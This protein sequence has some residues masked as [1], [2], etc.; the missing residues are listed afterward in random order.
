MML[1]DSSVMIN[2]LKIVYLTL[3]GDWFGVERCA[4]ISI[5]KGKRVIS[6]LPTYLPAASASPFPSL[7]FILFS[8]ANQILEF[9]ICCQME[10]ELRWMDGWKWCV[11]DRGVE[12]AAEI[13]DRGRSAATALL[14]VLGA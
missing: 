9:E 10:I 3:F 8:S 13:D 11:Y 5:S 2:L 6:C 7:Q 12:E 4:S 1:L 14:E